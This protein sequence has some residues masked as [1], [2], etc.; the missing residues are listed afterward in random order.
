MDIWR[1]CLRLT[2]NGASWIPVNNGLACGNIDRWRSIQRTN[3]HCSRRL[4]RG[5]LTSRLT[6][7]TGQTIADTG[8]TSTEISEL[9]IDTGGHLFMAIVL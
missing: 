7:A 6:T 4:R 2:N 8:L 5:R 1:C 9:G 3:F